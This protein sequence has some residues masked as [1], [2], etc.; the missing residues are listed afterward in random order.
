MDAREICAHCGSDDIVIDEARADC[1]CRECGSCEQQID[2]GWEVPDREQYDRCTLKRRSVHC[3]STYFVRRFLQS[4]QGLTSVEHVMLANLQK[5]V[6]QA[7]KSQKTGRKY[8]IS[9]RY[10]LKQLLH[11][12]GLTR[13]AHAVP[14]LKGKSKIAALDAIWTTLARDLQWPPPLESF[15]SSRSGKSKPSSSTPTPS[16]TCTVPS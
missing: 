15:P 6:M 7:L 1:I 9:Y 3:R 13:L 5:Q 2:I 8:T 10:Q 14:P 16:T 11:V 12:A 4:V